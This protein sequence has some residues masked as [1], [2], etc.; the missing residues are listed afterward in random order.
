MSASCLCRIIFFFSH[1]FYPFSPISA[2]WKRKWDAYE[3]PS[4]CNVQITLSET[5]VNNMVVFLKVLTI[6]KFSCRECNLFS[7]FDSLIVKAMSSADNL[8]IFTQTTSYFQSVSQFIAY[9]CYYVFTKK[10]LSEYVCIIFIYRYRFVQ[11][12]A[13]IPCYGFGCLLQHKCLFQF[14]SIFPLG[15]G[16]CL[17]VGLSHLTPCEWVHLWYLKEEK[18]NFLF[19]GVLFSLLSEL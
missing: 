2:Y 15:Q 8:Y 3:K 14:C 9:Y 4:F 13:L 11:L 10:Y 16:L 17:Q 5:P 6:L 1:L 12:L 18:E 19:H 7:I